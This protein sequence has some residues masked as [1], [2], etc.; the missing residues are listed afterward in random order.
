MSLKLVSIN[1]CSSENRY[2][3]VFLT[4][5]NIFFFVCTSS[6]AKFSTGMFWTKLSLISCFDWTNYGTLMHHGFLPP[7]FSTTA[8]ATASYLAEKAMAAFIII[9]NDTPFVTPS[10]FSSSKVA[11]MCARGIHLEKHLEPCTMA[12][13][14]SFS[15]CACSQGD[16]HQQRRGV[17]FIASTT[18]AFD[19]ATTAIVAELFLT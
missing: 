16:A 9:N 3:S 17:P 19:I 14:S 7:S 2:V 1:M 8:A 15:K 10:V 12:Q 18:T 11:M 6:Y 13:G 4:A 5:V